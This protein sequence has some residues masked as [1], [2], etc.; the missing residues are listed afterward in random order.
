MTSVTL[1]HS[2]SLTVATDAV[3]VFLDALESFAQSINAFETTYDSGQWTI[4]A[5]L[6]QDADQ[7]KIGTAIALA[8]AA[9]NTP[10]PQVAIERLQD[11]D[12]LAQLEKEFPP[13]RIGKFYLHGS[14][15]T[16]RPGDGP[17]R[18]LVNAGTAFGSGEHPT[19]QGCLRAMQDLAKRNHVRRV[20]DMG[21]G[22]GILSLAAAKL[23]RA[24]IIAVDIDAEAARVTT[25]NAGLNGVQ[26][27]IRAGA[28]NGYAAPIVARAPPADLIVCNIVAKPLKRMAPYLAQN[29]KPGGYAILSGLLHHQVSGVLAAHYAAGLR[30]VARYPI[31]E[32]RTLVLRK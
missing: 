25:A 21:C 24:Q 12:Y 4:T 7:T 11:I 26:R 5:I 28:G 1:S 22:S 32:W 2:A 16:P 17:V 15:H 6:T 13:F 19:T 14:H 23:W 10:E 31:G 20:I 27:L 29:L 8:A 18:L 3:P 9:A 30:L